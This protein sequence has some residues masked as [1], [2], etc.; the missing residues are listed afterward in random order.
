MP[1]SLKVKTRR[2]IMD[3]RALMHGS[4]LE[5]ICLLHGS[6]YSHLAVCNAMIKDVI[7]L[8]KALKL[9]GRK[10]RFERE[11]LKY[12]GISQS[13]RSYRKFISAT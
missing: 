7:D 1:I 11:D 10:R 6:D 4:M 12:R 3:K 2:G 8:K 5:D 9:K 13:L